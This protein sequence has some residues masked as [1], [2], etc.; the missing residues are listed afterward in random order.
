M[1]PTPEVQSILAMVLVA[2]QPPR[3][4]LCFHQ[5]TCQ[6]IYPQPGEGVCRLTFLS[7]LQQ[8]HVV[9]DHYLHFTDGETEAERSSSSQGEIGNS[10]FSHPVSVPDC[11]VS[12]STPAHSSSLWANLF[13][14]TISGKCKTTLISLLLLAFPWPPCIPSGLQC[15]WT[16]RPAS[17]ALQLENC[18]C[19]NMSLMPTQVRPMILKTQKSL[20]TQPSG[21]LAWPGPDSLEIPEMERAGRQEQKIAAEP[22]PRSA[23]NTSPPSPGHLLQPSQGEAGFN[24]ICQALPTP[25]IQSCPRRTMGTWA[26]SLRLCIWGQTGAKG[27]SE[28]GCRKVLGEL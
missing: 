2:K 11:Q 6:S 12:S 22:C 9:G 21:S 4:H 17:L 8:P 13:L 26:L 15:P 7:S 14:K 16:Q 20:Q 27:G 24:F 25:G 19:S 3:K 5:A 18:V 28:G 23:H 1:D 10:D